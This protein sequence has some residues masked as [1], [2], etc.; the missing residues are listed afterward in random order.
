MARTA[1][2]TTKSGIY[3]VVLRGFNRQKIFF[4]NSDRKAFLERLKRYKDQD[5]F[6]IFAYTLLDSSAH[7]ILKEDQ[8]SVSRLMQ[9]LQTSFVYYYNKKY[10]RAGAVF[11]DRFNSEPLENDL[12][13][14]SAMRCIC[15]IL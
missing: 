3:H 15:S 13:V 5:G 14:S 7:L 2:K 1:R 9:K 10:R 12:S 11:Q 4:D 6:K 8:I